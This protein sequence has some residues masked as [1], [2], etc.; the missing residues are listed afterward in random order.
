MRRAPTVTIRRRG[1]PRAFCATRRVFVQGEVV[2]QSH[3]HEQ[4]R[5]ANMRAIGFR[6]EVDAVDFAVVEGSV[7]CP[8]LIASQKI[9]APKTI[10]EI[11]ADSRGGRRPKLPYYVE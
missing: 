8:K 11:L 9:S 6:A 5:G 10:D 2:V 4:K 7:D 3:S 1:R